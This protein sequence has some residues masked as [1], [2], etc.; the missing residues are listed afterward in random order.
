MQVAFS[1][2]PF[3]SKSSHI[4]ATFAAEDIANTIFANDCSRFYMPE[5]I[6][7]NSIKTLQKN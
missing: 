7:A 5:L 4:I 6:I 2:S 3:P 1:P